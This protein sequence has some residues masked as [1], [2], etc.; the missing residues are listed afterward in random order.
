M[1]QCIVSIHPL[2]Q[3]FPIITDHDHDDDNDLLLLLLLLLSI[4][5]RESR[6]QT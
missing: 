2:V 1:L 3:C 5:E 4:S 6:K